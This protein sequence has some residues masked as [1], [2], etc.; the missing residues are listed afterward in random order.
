MKRRAGAAVAALALVLAACGE[1]D[2]PPETD[3]VETSESP[4]SSA[5]ITTEPATTDA[6]TELPTT[7]PTTTEPATGDPITLL[8]LG[9]DSRDQARPEEWTPGAQRTDVMMV[10]QIAGDRESVA[11]LSFPRDSWVEIPGHG[12]NKI[13]AAYS[14]GGPDLAEDT[15]ETLLGISIDHVL[16]TNFEGFAAMVDVLGGVTVETEDGAVELDSASALTFVRER[17]SLPAGD[18]DRIRRQQAFFAAVVDK[19]LT[20]DVANSPTLLVE[21]ATEVGPH[22]AINGE[23]GSQAMLSLT[24]VLMAASGITAEDLTVMSAP[25]AGVGWSADGQSIVELDDA[26]MA[27]VAEAFTADNVEDYVAANP[28]AVITLND[29]P[30]R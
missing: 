5:E 25:Y 23:S 6:S 20:E 13:N 8:V 1:S 28:D 30:V 17:M 4:S 18:F 3:A 21:F 12:E 11:V 19:L 9:H 27:D 14:L 24:P 26:R 22:V 16:V 10:V 29:E 2:D 7:E 15:V